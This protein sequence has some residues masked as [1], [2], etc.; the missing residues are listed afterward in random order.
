M[1]VGWIG[2]DVGWPINIRTMSCLGSLLMLTVPFYQNFYLGQL[3]LQIVLGSMLALRYSH[4]RPWLA[5]IGLALAATKP[6][7]GVIIAILLLFRGDWKNVFIG[8]GI[9]MAGSLI[10]LLFLWNNVGFDSFCNDLYSKYF[11][12]GSHPELGHAF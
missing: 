5:G 11:A 6:Q 2:H 10:G 7:F 4:D 3:P 8:A 1:L 12:L 9:S